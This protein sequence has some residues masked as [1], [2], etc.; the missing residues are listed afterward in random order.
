M[1][2]S[3][4]ELLRRSYSGC[5]CNTS[6]TDIWN[7]DVWGGTADTITHCPYCTD[8]TDGYTKEQ[9]EEHWRK[10][11]VKEEL[12]LMELSR[13]DRSIKRKVNIPILSKNVINK[14]MNRRMMNSR[15]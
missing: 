12:Q 3:F 10:E 5:N 6:T 9:E 11:E 15:H 13:I 7:E 2:I 4:Y 14:S 1:S 8:T